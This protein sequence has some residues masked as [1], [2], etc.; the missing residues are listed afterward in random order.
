MVDYTK[1]IPSFLETITGLICSPRDTIARLFSTIRPAHIG[2]ILFFF[3]LLLSIPV[4][5]NFYTAHNQIE[6]SFNVNLLLLFLFPTVNLIFFIIFESLFL[7]VL[8]LHF[9][10]RW[11]GAAVIYSSVPLLFI[12]ITMYIFNYYGGQDIGHLNIAL[13]DIVAYQNHYFKTIIPIILVIFPLLSILI[14]S[15]SLTQLTGGM[16]LST[17]MITICSAIP[18]AMSLICSTA[19]CNYLIEGSQK[20]IMDFFTAPWVALGL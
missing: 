15:F 14:F 11:L 10:F 9:S 4:I 12:I 16:F 17:L 3:Y 18:F 5:T 8:G 19:L 13:D 7:L 20:I 2:K 6:K 1:K